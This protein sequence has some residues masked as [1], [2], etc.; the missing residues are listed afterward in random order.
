MNPVIHCMTI[1]ELDRVH[2]SPG[3]R[4]YRDYLILV[5]RTTVNALCAIG[6]FLLEKD[7]VQDYMDNQRA[8]IRY[9]GMH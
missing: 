8:K 3:W 2:P 4:K 7:E 1:L 9:Y 5:Y 6:R